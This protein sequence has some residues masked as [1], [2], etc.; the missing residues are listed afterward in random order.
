MSKWQPIKTAPKDKSIRF[1]IYA[2][3]MFKIGNKVPNTDEVRDTVEAVMKIEKSENGMFIFYSDYDKLLKQ[4]EWQPI[5]TAPTNGLWILAYDPIYDVIFPINLKS[6]GH[7][8]FCF[9]DLKY[10]PTHWMPLP[11]PPTK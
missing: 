6:N 2:D 8:T 7:D 4:T 11:E 9:E 3:L 1:D 10:S 5:E